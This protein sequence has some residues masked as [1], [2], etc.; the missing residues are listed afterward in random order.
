MHGDYLIQTLHS[1]EQAEEDLYF[2]QQDRE[3]IARLRRA[4]ARQTS[5]SAAA[6]EVQETPTPPSE[7]QP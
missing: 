6:Q 5:D 1:K 2:A 7:Q 4:A 3:L